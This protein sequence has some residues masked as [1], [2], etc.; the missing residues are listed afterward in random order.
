MYSNI[1]TPERMTLPGLILS[2]FGVLGRRAVGCFEYRDAIADVAAGRDSESAD[3]RRRGIGEVVAVQVGR[4]DHRVL[5]RAEEQLLEHRVG[6]AIA[7]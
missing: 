4:R 7:A 2:R 6:D 3:L 5:R 1:I